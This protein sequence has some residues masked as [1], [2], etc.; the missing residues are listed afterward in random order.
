M[1][2]V[3]KLPHDDRNRIPMNGNN[4][5]KT[6][7]RIVAVIGLLASAAALPA[8]A[9]TP[10]SSYRIALESAEFFQPEG[11]PFELAV[12][13]GNPQ[14]GPSAV[15]MKFPPNFPGAMH[16]HT[17]GYHGM[18]VTGA[19]KHFIKGESEADVPLQTPG[20]Y[21]YQPGGEHHNDSFPTD[22]P[23]ILFIQWEGPMD[24]HFHPE[25]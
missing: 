3:V 18:V 1:D 9:E 5:I 17:H 21:W 14:K 25:D 15:F 16:S 7:T 22:E 24:V 20:D 10:E 6:I 2:G 11:A 4:M 19:S 8:Q 12:L 13:W 23:T